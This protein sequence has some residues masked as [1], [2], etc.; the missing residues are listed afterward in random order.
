M[1]SSVFC[2]FSHPLTSIFNI[3]ITDIKGTLLS[4]L[5]NVSSTFDP[6][7]NVTG[8]SSKEQLTRAVKGYR[9]G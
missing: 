9:P 4:L 8:A 7:F 2:K 3:I 1:D 5:G 6:F